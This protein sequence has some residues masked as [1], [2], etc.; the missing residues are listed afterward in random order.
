VEKSSTVI[1]AISVISTK[2]TQRTQSPNGPIFAQS[3]HPASQLQDGWPSVNVF[4]WNHLSEECSE[5]YRRDLTVCQPLKGLSK[6][7]IEQYENETVNLK[8]SMIECKWV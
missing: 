3:G 6:Q 2:T 4:L 5:V 8:L 1:C 7:Q